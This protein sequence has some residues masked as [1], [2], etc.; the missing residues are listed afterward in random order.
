MELSGRVALVTG[1]AG[2]IGRA[3]VRRFADA[4]ARVVAADVANS[5]VDGAAVCAAMDVTDAAAVA[6]VVGANGPI[7]VLVN[8]AA[9]TGSLGDSFLNEPMAVWDRQYDVTVKGAVHCARAVLPAMVERRYGSIV[10]IAS[11]NGLMFFGH[12]AYS[13]AKAALISLTQSLAALYGPHGVRV[14]AI[15]P[16]TIRTPVWDA[17]LETDPEKLDRLARW[18]PLGR[19]GEPSEIAEAACFL[20]SD[21][22]AWTS[23]VVLPVD[24]AVTAGNLAMA[25]DTGGA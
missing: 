17:R 3:L 18:Y 15:A 23:G 9:A 20:A 19:I 8:N 14:N 25:R 6:E 13:A 1:A 2:G 22:S 4:G 21:R 5:D 11:V 12:P 10:N 24:G 16:G 7:D